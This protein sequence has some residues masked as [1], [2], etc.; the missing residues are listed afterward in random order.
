MSANGMPH[1]DNPA[2]TRALPPLPC[3]APACFQ[4]A[5]ENIALA[6]QLWTALIT[7]V[8]IITELL[9]A[10]RTSGDRQLLGSNLKSI[11]ANVPLLIGRSWNRY[12]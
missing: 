7:P 9:V 1:C 10:A 12:S 5:V 11:P 2:N 3:E 6:T 8:E 4:S